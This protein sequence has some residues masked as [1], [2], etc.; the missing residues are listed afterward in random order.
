MRLCLS[1]GCTLS[2]R[3]VSI[4]GGQLALRGDLNQSIMLTVVMP[5]DITSVVCVV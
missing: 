4:L 3:N 5:E 1:A 2:V